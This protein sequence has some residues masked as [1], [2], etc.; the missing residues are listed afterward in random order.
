MLCRVGD[1]YSRKNPLAMKVL[2]WILLKNSSVST[3][4]YTKKPGS[5]VCNPQLIIS[6]Q[7]PMIMNV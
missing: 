4:L 2:Q 6:Q 5:G 3:G 1:E 7:F